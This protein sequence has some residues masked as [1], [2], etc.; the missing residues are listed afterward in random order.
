MKPL[1]VVVACFLLGACGGDDTDSR[2]TDPSST[3]TEVLLESASAV[4]ELQAL[5]ADAQ[6]SGSATSLDVCPLGRMQRN[7]DDLWVD[8]DGALTEPGLN[9]TR[10]TSVYAFAPGFSAMVSCDR[11]ANDGESAGGIGV[12][13]ML[14]PTSVRAFVEAFAVVDETAPPEISVDE[15][16]R[17]QGGQFYRV[18]VRY[19][20]DEV[21]NYCE[22]DWLSGDLLLGTYVA[23][24][25]ATDAD[26]AAVEAVFAAELPR[27]VETLGE[28]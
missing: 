18:C 1:G 9:G 22:V 13:A 19:P 27:Y 25:N 5:F 4:A 10:S 12:F 2:D 8:S 7:L 14:A 28:P 23:G 6:G 3:T 21:S 24:A 17:S 15:A 11:Y 26:L 20:D 16:G